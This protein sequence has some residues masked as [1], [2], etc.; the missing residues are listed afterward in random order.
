[1]FHVKYH[2]FSRFN[3]TSN[4]TVQSLGKYSGNPRG[5]SRCKKEALTD[6]RN[7]IFAVGSGKH[8]METE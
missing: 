3:H 8:I 4:A 6:V 1:M 7:E 2:L 5:S